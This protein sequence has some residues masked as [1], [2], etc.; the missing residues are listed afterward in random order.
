MP[1][2]PEIDSSGCTVVDDVGLTLR[3]GNEWVALAEAPREKRWHFVAASYDAGTGE[4]YLLQRVVERGPA[5][6]ASAYGNLG[7][8]N[9]TAAP[10]GTPLLLGAGALIPETEVG[11]YHCFNGKIERPCL[12]NRALGA[13]ELEALAGGA[14]PLAIPGVAAVWDFAATAASGVDIAD[15]TGSGHDGEAVNYPM[16]GLTGHNWDATAFHPG[17]GARAV[18]RHPLPRRRLRRHPLG[19][20]LRLYGARRRPQR[21]LR[22]APAGQ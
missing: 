3:V 22:R 8:P 20:G 11:A 21:L 7:A 9:G 12:F 5:P 13:E 15:V 10:A 2:G 16:R 14:D 17:G 6:P 4:A 18:R 1:T 19:G